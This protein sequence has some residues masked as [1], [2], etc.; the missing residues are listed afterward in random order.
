MSTPHPPSPLPHPPTRFL[1]VFVVARRFSLWGKRLHNYKSKKKQ[2]KFFPSNMNRVRI[3][4]PRHEDQPVLD[5]DVSVL[6]AN[7]GRGK[8]EEAQ[9]GSLDSRVQFIL[10]VQIPQGHHASGQASFIH[11]CFWLLPSTV[12]CWLL[13]STLNIIT[14]V[15]IIIIIIITIF[16]IIILIIMKI[17]LI[18]N[19]M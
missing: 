11:C 15:L 18:R 5:G 1:L 19:E 16:V 9:A 17:R 13:S 7:G 14:I 12:G 8:K 4:E 6:Y 10:F 3:P 2:N